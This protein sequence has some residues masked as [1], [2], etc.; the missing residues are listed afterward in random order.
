MKE[1][2]LAGGCFWGV[3]K[4]ISSINGVTLT[5]VGYANGNTES[6]T[7]EEVCH[8]NT[9][10]A[11]TVKVL[12]N[13]QIL[14]LSFLLG[15]FFKVIDPTSINRQGG[16]V[17]YQY[18]TGIYY[19][20]DEDIEVINKCIEDLEGKIGKKSVIEVKRLE[21][22]YLAEEYHQ[23]YLD[24]NPGGYCH[25]DFNMFDMASKAEDKK[26][27]SVPSKEEIKKNLSNI[28]YE[29]TQNSFTEPPF[30]NEYFNEFKEGIYVDVITEE[31]LFSSCDKFDSGCGWP[32][33]SK[34]IGENIIKEYNDNSHCMKRVEVRSALSNSHLGHVFNDGIKELGGLR[35][36]INSAALKFIPKEKMDE[37][38]Y[39]ELMRLFK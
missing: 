7:Y 39:G 34:P 32:A 27:Y 31:P 5:K 28:Q 3:E 35:Y 15:L 9:G 14:S 26:K 2:Y 18:R 30:Q 23:K 24:K 4:Y 25:I 8:N 13:P 12:Y 29:V 20:D 36:C 38:G 1:I 19:V 17:G 22:F 33:F 37:E 10:H 16:D 6:P 21:N 11:E